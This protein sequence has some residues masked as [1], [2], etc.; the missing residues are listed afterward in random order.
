MTALSVDIIEESSLWG[1]ALG[2]RGVI[3]KAAAAVVAHPAGSAAMR[4]GEAVCVALSDDASIARLNWRWRNQNVP[5][6]VLSFPT[7]PTAR[8]GGPG[9]LGDIVLAYETI[10]REARADGKTINDHVAHLVAH[11]MLH[12]LGYNHETEGEAE[13]MEA[14]EVS[15]LATIGIDDPYETEAA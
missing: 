3:T 12:L 13:H 5:T 9:M 4:G 14:L 8:H 15:I 6:N 10:E 7:L 11:A 2:L 1:K